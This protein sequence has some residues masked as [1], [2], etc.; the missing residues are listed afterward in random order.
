MAKS[1]EEM[2]EL[3]WKAHIEKQEADISFM[4]GVFEGNK[5]QWKSIE[6]SEAFYAQLEINSAQ[7]KLIELRREIER[8]EEII[9]KSE[10]IV[11]KFKRNPE[12][13]KPTKGRG[14]PVISEQNQA[15]GKKF[16]SQWVKSLMSVLEVNSCAQL[17]QI[18]DANLERSN[19]RNWRR[20]LNGEALLMYSTYEGLLGN[21]IKLGKYAGKL[22]YEIPTTPNSND[23]QTL[24]RFI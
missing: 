19:Q 8:Q 12:F 14:K 4:A 13:R 15:I 2:N 6:E 3:A 24:L 1:I 16:V 21:K 20:W 22:L 9:R 23:L 11:K 17:E 10:D 7:K 18:L 5:N